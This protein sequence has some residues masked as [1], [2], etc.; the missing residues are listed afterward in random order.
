MQVHQ[1]HRSRPSSLP[2]LPPGAGAVL[3]PDAVLARCGLDRKIVD[4]QEEQSI[5]SQ[6]D[7]AN[8]VF[9]I[10]KGRVRLTV[11]SKGG[12]EA[13]IALLHAGDFVGEECAMSIQPRRTTTATGLT[14]CTLLRFER[15]EFARAFH[16]ETAF[17]DVF[18]GFLIARNVRIQED[19]M[20]QLFNSS[21][22]RLARTLLLLARSGNDGTQ[23]T[24][25]PKISQETL[26]E[27][28][29]TTRSRVSCF[30]NRFRRMGYI[31]Y[32][33]GHNA[34]LRVHDS[35]LNVVLDS[36]TSGLETQRI[37]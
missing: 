18:V 15:G 32:N 37:G 1:P 16:E 35:L 27:M 5:F 36:I 11:I 8:A 7:D 3:T 28:V 25:V 17:S 22:K 13:T 23:E 30:M 10:Q 26:A 20:D 9:Y 31:D 34:V 4:V 24:A 21:E 29:G 33:T 14:A 12:K 2:K 19:L 6:G